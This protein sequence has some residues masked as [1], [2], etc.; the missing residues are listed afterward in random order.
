MQSFRRDRGLLVLAV[1]ATL[2]SIGHH[3][4]HI[5]RGNHV[6]WPLNPHVTPFTITLGFYPVIALGF[7]LYLTGR[8]G[9][10]FWTALSVVGVLFVSLNHFG[11][12]AVEPPHDILG[13]YHSALAG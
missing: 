9:A 5:A 4:D 3:I 1:I 8:V 10:G 12:L 7:Y 2:F 13:A 6:G 11:P